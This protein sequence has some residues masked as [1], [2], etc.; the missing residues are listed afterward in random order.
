MDIERLRLKLELLQE[1]LQGR[2]KKAQVA[3]R[4]QISLR[5]VERY[6]QRFLQMGPE[7]LPPRH[8][9][10]F[11]KLTRQDELR[12]VQAKRQALHRS[13]RWV[14]D[15]LQMRVH[16]RTVW[17]VFVQHGLNRI[18]LPPSSRPPASRPS[19]PMTCG[20]SISWGS[21]GSPKS[22]TA[23]SFCSRMTARPIFWREGGCERPASSTLRLPLPR[24][25]A[26]RAAEGNPV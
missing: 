22:A 7:G 16:E 18:T 17:R 21:S 4:L 13:V 24:L 1:W 6:H 9:S 8:T 25:H 11:R 19:R 5:T 23:T 26:Q 10:H 20:S 2:L 14:R 12:I 3:E 15:H